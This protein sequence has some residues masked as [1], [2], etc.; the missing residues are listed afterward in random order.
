M[1]HELR[2]RNLL[3]IDLLE[4]QLAPGFNVLTGETGAGKSV[5]VGAL[6]LV[7]GTR[8]APDKIR[9]GAKNAEV[10]ALFQLS[11]PDALQRLEA[12][13]IAQG[14]ELV[15]RRTLHPNARSRA[16]LNG[17]LSPVGE[18]A[19]LA[20]YLAD[21]ASQHESVS[22][23]DV[24]TH[25]GYL[26]EFG[27]LVGDR[28]EIRVGVEAL[29]AVR[30]NLERLRAV[31][32]ERAERQEFLQFQLSAIE[33][34]A[35]TLGEVESLKAERARLRNISR[36][37]AA[38]GDA[39]AKLSPHDR[40]LCD[41]LRGIIGSLSSAAE[42][43][44]V[45]NE[46][47]DA[48]RAALEHLT[49]AGRALERYVEGLQD[50]PAR[51]EQ[52]EHRLYEL[53]QL[54][55]RHGP[56]EADAIAAA[57]RLRRE[58]EELDSVDDAVRREQE[59]FEQALAKT[60]K[61]AFALSKKRSKAAKSLAEAVSSELAGLGMG[62]ARVQVDVARHEGDSGEL[63]VEGAKLTAQG[64]DR[65]EFLIAPNKGIAPKP[66]RKIASGGELSRS[67]LAIKRILASQGPAGLYVFDEVDAGVG[68]AV[69]ERIGDALAE[70][71]KHRQVLCITHLAPI[72]AL[73]DAHFVVRKSQSGQV[74][75]T[76][77]VRVTGDDRVRE[78]ARMLSG[79]KVTDASMQ[80]AAEMI[81]RA[82]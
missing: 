42:L 17:R 11:S 43:D 9:P 69:A 70:I 4:L 21:I 6:Q 68:G 53:E 46:T 2:V 49:E 12:S 78:V 60:G 55:R 62:G 72:A 58:L 65:V 15:I 63:V 74:A 32:R 35:P 77:V 44:D 3:L 25:I 39:A 56:T 64:V 20:P 45:L 51:L 81:A 18:L 38:A 13:G 28:E 8:G 23:T 82:P 71:A 29:R 48:T 5:V 26:D 34:V 33:D 57:D 41:E 10:E 66:L 67:L 37:A 61:A 73:A 1:L 27:G 79:A 16:Y 80:A 76:D 54:L 47:L 24:S 7:L 31:A 75:R 52:I 36:L 14:D 50:D 59:R 40:G 30:E 22:L 19:T